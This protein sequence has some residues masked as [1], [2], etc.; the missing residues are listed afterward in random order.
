MSTR[1]SSPAAGDPAATDKVRRTHRALLPG[2]TRSRLV[3]GN[4]PL[5]PL[6]HEVNSAAVNASRS[7]LVQRYR[8]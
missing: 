3:T 5:L 6:V 2:R 8:Q 7:T 4:A 1:V